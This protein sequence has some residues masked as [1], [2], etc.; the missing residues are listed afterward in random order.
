MENQFIIKVRYTKQLENGTFKRVSENYLFFAQSF[1]DAEARVYEELGSIIRGEFTVVAI[2]RAEFHD[3][4]HYEECDVW[5]KGVISFVTE[6]DDSG[7]EKKAK[8]TLLVSAESVKDADAKLKE[9]LSG[10]MVDYT[11]DGI[12]ITNLV[13]IFPFVENLDVEISRT[14]QTPEDYTIEESVDELS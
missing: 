3:I 14:S 11:I 9:S 5:Y 7:K 2:T 4:F 8:Q 13:D 10:M 12:V 6:S 1:S